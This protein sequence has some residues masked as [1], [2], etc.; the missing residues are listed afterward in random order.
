[1]RPARIVHRM[2]DVLS[3]IESRKADHIS[4]EKGLNGKFIKCDKGRIGYSV[5]GRWQWHKLA[6]ER[7]T[8]EER[9]FAQAY[10]ESE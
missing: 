4:L 9:D 5:S 2:Y 1:M 6:I 3:D 8:E 10:A 7:Y